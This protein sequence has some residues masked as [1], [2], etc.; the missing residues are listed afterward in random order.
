MESDAIRTRIAKAQDVIV[1]KNTLIEKR[2]KTIGKIYAKIGKFCGMDEE[3]TATDEFADRF[4]NTVK[5][6]FNAHLTETYQK[7]GDASNYYERL[8]EG[9]WNAVQDA[10]YNLGDH[11]ESIRNARAEIKNREEQIVKYESMLSSELNREAV[12]DTMPECMKDFMNSVIESWDLWD[13]MKRETVKSDHAYVSELY[14]ERQKVHLE[15][16]YDSEKYKEIRAEME[17]IQGKYSYYEWSELA[18]MKDDEIHDRNVK[19]GKILVL[20]LYDRVT[21]IT[22]AFTD[23]SALKVTSGNSGFAVING[24]IKGEKGTASVKSVG[25]GGWNI[26]RFH[27]RTLVHEVH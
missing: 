25:A 10:Y 1:K 22:G 20:N 15:F 19:A 18:Y 17:E 21:E 16:G 11:T 9:L 13:K 3:F 14:N 27:I 26:Q 24:I 6:V 12:F 4:E 5:T 23:A 8:T 2:F 7:Y